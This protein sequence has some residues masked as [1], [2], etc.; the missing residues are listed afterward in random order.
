MIIRFPLAAVWVGLLS[1]IQ[2]SHSSSVL[3]SAADATYADAPY[4]VLVFSKTAGFRHSSIPKSIKAI[5]MLGVVNN[6]TNWPT[7]RSVLFATW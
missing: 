7:D 4:N 5:E 3:A 1:V 2:L 6:F